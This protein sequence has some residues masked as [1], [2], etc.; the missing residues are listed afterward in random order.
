MSK[1]G[2]PEKVS[3]ENFE[4]LMEKANDIQKR[5]M[6]FRHLFLYVV[7][8]FFAVD[9]TFVLVLS[10]LLALQFGQLDSF[11]LLYPTLSLQHFAIFILL[12]A[13]SSIILSPFLLLVYYFLFW[14][15]YKYSGYPTLE[16]QIFSDAFVIANHLKRDERLIAQRW[17]DWFLVDVAAF[18]SFLMINPKR[19][20]YAPEFEQLRNG[21][22]QIKRMVMFS[23]DNISELF[24]DFGL[25]FVRS[26]DP[27]AFTNLNKII[28]NAK[29]YGELKSRIG[30]ALG[31]IEHYPIS[32][33]IVTSIIILLLAIVF[34]FLFGH[35]LPFS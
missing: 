27:K 6:D 16:E 19:K 34:Y 14:I 15:F 13:I 24:A 7:I 2:Y 28:E 25:A 32:L 5:K 1:N 10:Y 17:V 3:K 8:P 23:N 11:L 12:V 18:C 29:I 20:I 9:L 35:P 22:N 4:Q 30:S 31:R 21:K 33:Q 26:D